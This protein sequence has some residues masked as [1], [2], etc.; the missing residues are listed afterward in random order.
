M[1]WDLCYS[2][3][4]SPGFHSQYCI[5][6]PLHQQSPKSPT[7]PPS[8]FPPEKNVTFTKKNLNTFTFLDTN[9]NHSP[10]NFPQRRITRLFLPKKLNVF[11]STKLHM[12]FPIQFSSQEKSP[13]FPTNI[14]Q[15]VHIYFNTLFLLC[16]LLFH[17][18]YHSKP[19]AIPTLQTAFL[20][21]Q[22][23]FFGCR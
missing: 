17:S 22:S 3:N 2:T 9:T 1:N 4:A 5:C 21:L 18:G 19:S 15:T 13:H 23:G 16:F 7:K 14:E 10:S 11:T 12:L 8:N 20:V 6:Q